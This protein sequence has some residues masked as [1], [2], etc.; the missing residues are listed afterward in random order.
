MHLDD[1][2]LQRALHGE[3]RGVEASVR[4]HLDDCSDCR[5]RLEEARREEDWV[6]DRLHQLDRGRP[7]VSVESVLTRRRQRNLPRWSRLA[8]GIFLALAAAGVAYAAPGSPLPRMV[9]RL[10]DVVSRTPARQVSPAPQLPSAPPEAGIAVTPGSRLTIALPGNRPA[11]TAVVSL[12]SGSDVVV[13][14]VGGTTSFNS[15]AE[16]LSITQQG[17]PA[18]FEILLPR[19][20]PLVEVRA[21]DRRILLKQ[22][23]RIITDARPNGEGRYVLPLSHSVP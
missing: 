18:T 1:E 7:R 12:T 6:F 8:A 14:A 20:A 5:S 16:R 15:D 11:D 19:T 21:G 22:S 10:I 4:H 2:Q 3:L 9:S 17:A 23:S 13:R